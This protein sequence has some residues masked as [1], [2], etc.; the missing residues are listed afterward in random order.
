M[1]ATTSNAKVAV[2]ALTVHG[3]TLARRLSQAL[4]SRLVL[5]ARFAQ[6][7]EQSFEKGMFTA[8]CQQLFRDVDCVICVM[9]TGIVVRTIAPLITDKTVD[10]AVLVIDEQGHHVISLLSGHVGGANAWTTQ[11]A[12]ILDS[13]PVITTATD[14]ENVQALDTL[15]QRVNGWYPEFKRNTKRFNGLLAAGKPVAIYVDPVFRPQL[16]DLR[17]W[18]VV[19]RVAD[20]PVEVPLVIVSDRTDFDKRTD[21]LPV[22]PR[23]NALGIGCRR[24]VTTQMMQ[25]TFTQFCAAHHLAW[26]SIA[27][28]G[29]IDVKQHEAAIQMLS[30]T[31][32]V[33]VKFFTADT[34]RPASAHYPESA[35][36]AK[37][38]GVGNVAAA[39]AE[40]LTGQLAVTDRFAQND[41]TMVLGRQLD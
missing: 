35:F 38:V 9:A 24:D 19:E 14:T 17:G 10:P 2:I 32:N 30:A 36:V 6:S 40:V 20:A 25:D 29:S 23:L 31:L 18:T 34:L 4:A 27:Q 3:A 28:L 41:I 8:T 39:S 13:D 21:T 7:G 11:V 1:T 5:P 33:P 12:T 22:I 26:R 15:A 16:T 37:T